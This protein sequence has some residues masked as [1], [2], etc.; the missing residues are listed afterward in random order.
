MGGVQP[1]AILGLVVLAFTCVV[2]LVLRSGR[3]RPLNTLWLQIGIGV[4]P[5]VAGA[6]YV[7]N[8][9]TD[10]FPDRWER[11]VVVATV[12]LAVA[13]GLVGVLWRFANR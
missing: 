11:P 9:E 8:K 5:G 2:L 12:T 13:L 4:V 1:V 6:V 7:L 10:F 3:K